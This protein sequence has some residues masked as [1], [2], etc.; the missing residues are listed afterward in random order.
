MFHFLKCRDK[1][2]LPP[3]QKPSSSLANPFSVLAIPGMFLLYKYNEFRRLQEEIRE[4]NITEKEL[5]KLNNKIVSKSFFII[6]IYLFIYLKHCMTV[7]GR[8]TF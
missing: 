1:E 6:I 2:G 8:F 5:K 7:T 3:K 4:K